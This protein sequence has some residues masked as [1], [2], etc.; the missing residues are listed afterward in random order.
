MA[1]SVGRPSRRKNE[2]GIFP[3]A[4]IRS[5]TSTVRGK[6]SIPSRMPRLAWAVT[7]TVVSPTDTTTAP[8]A[9]GA[10]RPVEKVRDLPVSPMG[11]DAVIGPVMELLLSSLFGSGRGAG[12]QLACSGARRMATDNRL[13][14]RRKTFEERRTAPR[15][16][17][18]AKP[19]PGDE[20]P[21]PLDVVA[22]EVVEQATSPAD[23]HQ[24]PPA[25]VMILLVDLQVR[26]E[27][28]DPLREERDLNL[29]G[30]GVGLVEA[31]LAD[32]GGGVWHRQIRSL[33]APAGWLGP[34]VDGGS[35]FG[36][37]SGWSAPGRT[38]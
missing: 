8:S 10:S 16:P 15:R 2:P 25:G 21:V 24:Q 17:L 3:A 37:A 23:K 30:T 11:A 12:S 13:R 36:Y 26:R 4:Y 9:W 33:P 14:R 1:C 27:H 32:R 35:G 38:P 31:V 18:P 22:A 28:V 29:G 20:R 34:S 19:E 6:K 7:R 5:S